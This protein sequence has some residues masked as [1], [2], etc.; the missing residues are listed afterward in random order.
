MTELH[1]EEDAPFQLGRLDVDG[2]VIK[3]TSKEVIAVG[4][5][6]NSLSLYGGLHA[7]PT[8]SIGT[9]HSDFATCDCDPIRNSPRKCAPDAGNVEAPWSEVA[10]Q[11]HISYDRVGNATCPNDYHV[12][13][14]TC[15]P[16][17]VVPIATGNETNAV[18]SPLKRA[19]L[20][21]YEPG[22]TTISYA[23]LSEVK[24]QTESTPHERATFNKPV[25]APGRTHLR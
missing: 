24:K 10:E 9:I 5:E 2:S 17:G 4:K 23:S 6:N 21:S 1:S 22:E 13:Y 18:R 19:A 12:A 20:K 16:I 25:R 7:P 14:D 15:V 11:T 8:M 3:I